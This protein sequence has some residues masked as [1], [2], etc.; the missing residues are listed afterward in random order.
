[1]IASR[2]PRFEADRDTY[3]ETSKRLEAEGDF[4][5]AENAL[6]RA[7][8][9]EAHLIRIENLLDRRNA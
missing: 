3:V 9:C 4:R 5:G 1:V 2:K 7:K 6:S 8:L